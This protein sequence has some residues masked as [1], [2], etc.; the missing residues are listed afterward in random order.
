MRETGHSCVPTDVKSKWQGMFW[1]TMCAP[2]S[3]AEM[4]HAQ[5]VFVTDAFP[6]EATYRISHPTP[7]WLSNIFFFNLTLFYLPLPS[8]VQLQKL[9]ST[10]I[11]INS[12]LS[13]ST[14]V[15]LY[16]YSPYHCLRTKDISAEKKNSLIWLVTLVQ[17]LLCFHLPTMD[18]E[19]V[20]KDQVHLSS[21]MPKGRLLCTDQTG[22]E[23]ASPFR[24]KHNSKV[25]FA[26]K[27]LPRGYRQLYKPHLDTA[28]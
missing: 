18:R 20:Q 17:S 11:D 3:S 25:F 6:P 16:L 7:I 22:I 19:S 28:R 5:D 1:E 4:P 2:V 14:S 12:S 24:N 27:L 10:P 26:A 23:Y 21:L 9:S 13:S 8:A 15:W